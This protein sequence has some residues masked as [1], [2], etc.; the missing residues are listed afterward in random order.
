MGDIGEEK[1]CEVIYNETISKFGRI[2][3]LINNAGCFRQ[4]PLDTTSI[5]SFDDV[6]RINARSVIFLTQ[7]CIPELKKT[8]GSIVNVSSIAGVRSF[9]GAGYY[10][11]SKVAQDMYTKCLALELAPHGV[12]VNAVNP[13]TV[14]TPVFK[15]SGLT[16]EQVAGFF[17]AEIVLNPIKRIGTVED[18]A[19]LIAFLAGS[20]ASFITGNITSVDGGRNLVCPR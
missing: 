12:R 13:G 9:V 19:D 2:D 20:R 5:E 14:D 17:E 15:R 10:C 16:D 11:M 4:G 18:V 1:T 3:I 7:L 8:K 6:I